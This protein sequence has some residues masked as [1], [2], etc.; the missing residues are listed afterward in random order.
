[1]NK[2]K[3]TTTYQGVRG[4]K[5]HNNASGYGMLSFYKNG[6]NKVDISVD[7]FEGFGAD[8][9]EREDAQITISFHDG[10]TVPF[11]GTA[12]ELKKLLNP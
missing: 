11:H 8:Y 10:K 12:D 6:S 7:T 9:K 3:L 2:L 1:M 5:N 4:G